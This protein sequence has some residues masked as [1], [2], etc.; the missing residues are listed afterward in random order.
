MGPKHYSKLQ[1]P[2]AICLFQ[3]GEGIN[4]PAMPA[5]WEGERFKVR[6]V[7]VYL[8]YYWGLF[9]S[10]TLAEKQ[11]ARGVL[12]MQQR[13]HLRDTWRMTV[14]QVWQQWVHIK[15]P[16]HLLCIHLRS[17]HSRRV[18]GFTVTWAALC[19]WRVW[20]AVWVT[21]APWL[22]AVGMCWCHALGL[23][24]QGTARPAGD[25]IRKQYS[26]RLLIILIWQYP[27]I[28][29]KPLILA[30]RRKV[31]RPKKNTAIF[32]AKTSE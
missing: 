14:F 13:C 3:T 26:W 21:A 6:H 11:E 16:L 5:N 28:K 19:L 23:G 25:K 9:V 17:W 22:C 27:E 2:P 4:S 10:E 24:L 8:C 30:L 20:R 1:F 15:Q 29:P 7:K 32:T 18:V 12:M 31:R